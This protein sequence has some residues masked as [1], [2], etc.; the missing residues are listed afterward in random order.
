LS[1]L[2]ENIKRVHTKLQQVLKQYLYLQKENT[3]LQKELAEAKDKRTKD[4]EQIEALKLQVIILKSATGQ[5]DAA[6]KKLL[7]K[8]ITQYIKEVDKCISLLSE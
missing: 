4:L 5:M 3:N 7:D 2:Q 6:D 8:Q 1:L